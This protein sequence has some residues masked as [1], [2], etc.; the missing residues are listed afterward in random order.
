[1]WR[2][3]FDGGRHPQHRDKTE[4]TL[5]DDAFFA[6][7]GQ[8]QPRSLWPIIN[9]IMVDWDGH[10]AR[11]AGVGKVILKAWQ[12]EWNPPREVVFI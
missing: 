3:A 4:E 6:K 10:M 12:E 5:G 11:R 2:F 7:R 9:V 1:M 8:P